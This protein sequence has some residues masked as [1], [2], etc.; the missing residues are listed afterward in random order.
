MDIADTG[1][2]AHAPGWWEAVCRVADEED[3]PVTH[4]LGDLGRHVP[5]THIDHRDVDVDSSDGVADQRFAAIGVVVVDALDLGVE[6]EHEH[7]V[8]VEVVGDEDTVGAGFEDEV[9][10]A[11]A[12]GDCRSQV[13]LE[14][15]SDEAL[16]PWRTLHLDAER[17]AHTA[18]GAVGRK[19]VPAADVGDLVAAEVADR[20]GDRSCRLSGFLPLGRVPQ[21]DQRVFLRDVG[22]QQLELVLG[23]VPQGSGCDSQAFVALVLIRQTPDE[24]AVQAGQEV[25]VPGIFRVRGKGVDRVHVEAGLAEDLEGPGVD[26][27]G[28]G[29]AQW[30]RA[31]FQ[32]DRPPAPAG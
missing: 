15:D 7:P 20:G 12:F 13:G 2:E 1:V 24:R 5:R 9:Q 32:H 21:V 22:E 23:D 3:V 6:G 26:C 31:P 14:V 27:V 11:G 18:P 30:P 28:S 8:A 16:D 17:L 19:Q 4:V 29:V 10:D 25:D